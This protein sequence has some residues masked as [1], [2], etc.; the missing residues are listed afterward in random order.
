MFLTIKPCTKR[1]CIFDNGTVTKWFKKFCSVCRNLDDQAKLCKSKGGDFETLLQSIMTIQESSTLRV[2][3]DHDI[4][5]SSVAHLLIF[6]K[7]IQR[8]RNVP[9]AWKIVQ[10]WEVVEER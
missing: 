7:S 2:S 1:E 9:D 5:Q 6:R 4:L 10:R 8:C 3:D